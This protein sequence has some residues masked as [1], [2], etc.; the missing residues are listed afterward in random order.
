MLK[1]YDVYKLQIYKLISDTVTGFDLEHNKFTL[2]SSIHLHN[3]IFSK[4]LILQLKIIEQ[5]LA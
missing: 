2:A 1:S 5:D 3:K 4:K